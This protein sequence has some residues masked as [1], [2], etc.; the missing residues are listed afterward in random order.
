MATRKRPA[1]VVAQKFSLRQPPYVLRGLK[2]NFNVP[3]KKR[4]RN[5]DY[6]YVAYLDM[7][8]MSRLALD[9]PEVALEVIT[10][11]R[12]LARIAESAVAIEKQSG[13]KHAV[14]VW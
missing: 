6:R 7:L 1:S 14:R 11:L 9:Q 13:R 8:G 12:E 10:R 5:A 2:R 3:Q 4:A